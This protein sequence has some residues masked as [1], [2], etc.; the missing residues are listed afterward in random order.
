M[1]PN[2][3]IRLLRISVVYL[4]AGLVIGLAIG[5]SKSFWLASVHSHI[6]LLGWAAMSV[7]GIAY[8]VLPGCAASRLA[9]FHFWGHNLGLPVMMASLAL[10]AFGRKDVEPAIGVGST[11]VLLSLT[12]FAANLFRN[13]S[14]AQTA[15]TQ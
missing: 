4:V 14:S 1:K 11:V 15:K 9:T 8:L 5:M 12:L 6:L 2:I 7:S 3:G 13:A 10:E